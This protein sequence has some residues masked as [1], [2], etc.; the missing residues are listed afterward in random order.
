MRG[1]VPQRHLELN[2]QKHAE[3]QVHAVSQW[4]RLQPGRG[5]CVRHRIC[6]VTIDI[7]PAKASPTKAGKAGPTKALSAQNRAALVCA[8]TVHDFL[9]IGM[10]QHFGFGEC[11]LNR[12][13]HTLAQVMRH[14]QR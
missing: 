10:H 9:R 12:L 14:R 4:D 8:I 11:L 6:G 7:F 13:F 3:P 5:Q 2:S 1:P